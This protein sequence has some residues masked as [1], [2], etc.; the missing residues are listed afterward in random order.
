MNDPAVIDWTAALAGANAT[1]RALQPTPAPTPDPCLCGS[2]DTRGRITTTPVDLTHEDVV[3]ERNAGQQH[4]RACAH[5]IG[6]DA[7]RV[8]SYYASTTTVRDYYH[9]ECVRI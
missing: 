9:P 3:C 8:T 2:T 5:G 4:C 6:N 1:V 7:M